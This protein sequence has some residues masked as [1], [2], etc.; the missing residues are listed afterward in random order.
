[1]EGPRPHGH[2]L[3]EMLVALAIVGVVAGWALPSFRELALNAA[4]TQQVNAFLQA[5]YLARS[6]AI[7]RNAV[8]SLCPSPDGEVCRQAAIGT[9]AGSCSRTSTATRRRSGTPGGPAPGLSVLDGRPDRRQPYNPV[10]RAF[11]QS[12]GRDRDVL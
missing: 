2:T 5:V 9:G 3:I 7:K 8:V 1:M 10:V 11:G 12:G 6:E 4:R